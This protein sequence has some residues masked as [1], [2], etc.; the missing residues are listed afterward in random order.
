MRWPWWLALGA[1][2]LGAVLITLFCPPER[3]SGDDPLAALD[4]YV[5]LPELDRAYWLPV[6][7]ANDQ[8][9]FDA[10]A[11]CRQQHPPRPNCRTVL[12]LEDALTVPGF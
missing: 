4:A 5:Q 1:V 9:W 12:R 3:P 8:R 7:Q 6:A 2:V 11:V 10:L